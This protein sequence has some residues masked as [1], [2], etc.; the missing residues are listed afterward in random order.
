M[1]PQRWREIEDLYH[2]ALER[3]PSTRAAFLE[4]ADPELRREVESLLAESGGASFLERPAL[5]NTK[6][7]APAAL[8][9][10]RLESKLGEGGMG[11]VFRG[12]DTRLGRPVAIKFAHARF[13][14]RFAREARAISSLNHPNICTL[15]DVGPNYLVMELLEGP[16]LAE[17]LHKGPIPFN[18]AVPLALQVASALEAAHN[19]GIIHRDLKPGNIMLTRSGVKVLDFGLARIEEPISSPESPETSIGTVTLTEVGTLAG[20]PSYM[21]PEQALGHAVDKRADIWAFGVVLWETLTGKRL[22][23]GNSA[24]EIMAAVLAKEPNWNE[25]PLP[26]RRLVRSCLQRDIDRRLHDIGDAAFLIDAAGEPPPDLRAPGRAGSWWKWGALAALAALAFCLALLWWGSARPAS[27]PFLRFDVQLGRER[28]IVGRVAISPDGGRIAFVEQ[29]TGGRHLMTRRLDQAEATVLDDHMGRDPGR[30]P[31][32]SPDGKWIGYSA[33]H[34]LKKIPVEGGVPIVLVGDMTAEGVSTWGDRDEIVSHLTFAGLSR[35]PAAGGAPQIIA[36]DTLTVPSFLPGGKALLLSGGPLSI[37]SVSGG[38]AKAIEGI[39]S[40]WATYVDSGFI[41]YI[42]RARVLQ[43]LPFDASHLTVKGSPFPIEQDVDSFDVSRSGTLLFRHS[44]PRLETVQMVDESGKAQAIL[45]EPGQYGFPAF[46]P[47][48]GRLAVTMSGDKVSQ[49]WVCDLARGSK[50][51]LTFESKGA[52][53]PVWTSDGSDVLF[54]GYGGIFSVPANGSGKARQ[55]LK[56]EGTPDSISPDGHTLA[57]TMMDT[58]SARDIWTVPLTGQGEGLSAGNPSPLINSPADEINPAFSPNGKWLAYASS[59]SGA[60]LV[61]VKS[62]KNPDAIWQVSTKEGFIPQWSPAKKEIIF[63]SLSSHVLWSASYSENGDN[64]VPGEV[65]PYGGS[66]DFPSDGGA[67]T[68]TIAPSGNHVAALVLAKPS[69]A[70][71][72]RP[73]FVLMMNL[74]DEL[75]R[76]VAETPVR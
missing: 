22:F 46:S 71:P 25:L 5:Q 40:R 13:G 57:I 61:Y 9:P 49:I 37:L 15:Y 2:A 41:L 51:R 39:T 16:T 65:R 29:D 66:T 27:R 43:A 67:P 47:D 72:E 75:R 58:H 6:L 48:G 42:D 31:F 35:V 69:S 3:E 34:S 76:H 33:D 62:L 38:A 26:A 55:I 14:S 45:D 36:P 56:T 23:E 4:N 24:R 68:F 21:A 10:Y 28:E 30:Y 44:E 7:S 20:T 18:E 70:N 74:S 12:V 19:R 60:F 73:P 59:Q 53:Y 63:R 17:R 64:F 52:S 50:N 32:F 8:G 11:E 54:R 1:N